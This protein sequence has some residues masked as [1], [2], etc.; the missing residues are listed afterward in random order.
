MRFKAGNS[1]GD[2]KEPNCSFEVL[3]ALYSVTRMFIQREKHSML[4]IYLWKT[5]KINESRN[6]AGLQLC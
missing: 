6:Y 3:F 1:T 5:K 2:V 4:K